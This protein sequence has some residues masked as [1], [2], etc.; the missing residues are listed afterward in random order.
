MKLSRKEIIT[1]IK[2]F[3]ASYGSSFVLFQAQGNRISLTAE[4]EESNHTEFQLAKP[5]Q[6]EINLSL[7]LSS[8]NKLIRHLPGDEVEI[9][10]QGGDLLVNCA[11]LTTRFEGIPG[12]FQKQAIISAS[13]LLK[14]LYYTQFATSNNSSPILQGIFISFGLSLEMAATDGSRLS[15]YQNYTA[16]TGVSDSFNFIISPDSANKINNALQYAQAKKGDFDVTFHAS[17][18]Y[19][20]V[21]YQDES[22]LVHV[23][24]GNF[25]IPGSLIPKEF[26]HMIGFNRH[27]MLSAIQECQQLAQDKSKVILLQFENNIVRMLPNIKSIQEYTPITTQVSYRGDTLE[28][29]FNMLFLLDYLKH[30]Q[31]DMLSLQTSGELQPTLISGEEH[32][33]YLVM[34]VSIKAPE[35]IVV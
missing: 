12:A 24:K 19:V 14:G 7:F 25:P 26:K 18:D 8:F 16:N 15:F 3:E 22:F 29:A 10:Q 4:F 30:C 34:P 33:Q 6:G 11:G 17:G 31:S 32:V 2:A 28:I 13:A 21:S 5:V 23:L 1:L 20:T 35:T 9:T 27:A